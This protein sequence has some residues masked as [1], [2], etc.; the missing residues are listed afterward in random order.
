MNEITQLLVRPNTSIREA[1]KILDTMGLTIVLLV[2]DQ[3][4]LRRTV[5]DGDLRRLLMAGHELHSTLS[6][7]PPQSP[8]TTRD[9][10]DGAG[11][12]ALMN[13]LLI[14]QLP[15]VDDDHRPIGL[16]LRRDLDTQ[17]L[18]ST[19][20]MG[21]K[22]IQYIESAFRSNWIAPLGPNV[23]AFETEMTQYLG[24]GYAAAVISG[25]AAIHLAL[26]L[27]GVGSGDRVFCSSL[28]F[29]ASANPILYQGA[30]PVFIDSEPE[31]WN[32]SPVALERALVEAAQRNTLPK[33][34][35]VVNLYG[36]SA[37][38]DPILRLCDRY[39]VPV[40]ED[41]A[42]SL[43]ATYKGRPSGTFGRLGVFSF[44]GNKI[45]TTS[46]GG[47]IVSRDRGLIE[48]ARF[49][50][51]QARDPAPY[52]QHSAAGYNYRLSNV[53]AGIGRGQ[54]KVLDERVN[55]RRAI[56]E[57][58]RTA[59][60]EVTALDW[61]PEPTF[62]RSTRW[63]SCCLLSPEAGI[64]PADMIAR[65]GKEKIEARHVWKPLHR[66]PLFVDC[67]YYPHTPDQSV[68]DL[69]FARGVCLPSGSNLTDE[70]LNRVIR[71]I[72][73]IVGCRA[74]AAV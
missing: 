30:T 42:E 10:E 70:Q 23:D 64:R 56:F 32:M 2:D 55:K 16:F 59:L 33:A 19:P 49:L 18:L 31:S 38:L 35:V 5:T 50:S 66:Q 71:V 62:G 72:Q 29:V 20:H 63:L 7:L 22:E 68:S 27:L 41:A 25:T 47:M 39:E 14:D 28:T 52:Y 45:I 37:D 1:M 21:E 73:N 51:T 60:A 34:V 46:G 58:Y 40:V 36:Q 13:R 54:L 15:V 67:T 69:C 61:M 24:G 26:R 3:G 17:I 74:S 53:L 11:A 43:G 44:N 65:L 8:T 9:A 48:Q 12:L 6:A 4:R 57:R